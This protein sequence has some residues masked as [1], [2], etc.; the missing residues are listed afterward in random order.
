MA[1]RGRQVP[2]G[3]H[4]RFSEKGNLLAESSFDAKGRVTRERS[5]DENGELQ[6]DEHVLEDGSRKAYTQ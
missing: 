4:R 1:G 2:V 5:W 3:T 6:H